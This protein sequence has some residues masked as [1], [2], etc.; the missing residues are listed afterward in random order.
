MRE[1]RIV[2]NDTIEREEMSNLIDK[3]ITARDVKESSKTTY[4]K[5]LKQFMTWIAGMRT[6][7][8]TRETILHYKSHIEEKGLTALTLSNYIGA[9]R[10][11]FEWLEEENIYPNVAKGIKGAKKP[12]G[13]RKDTFTIEQVKALFSSA[14]RNTL[15]GKRD[16]AILNLLVRTGLRTIEVA[17]ANFDDIRQEAGESILWVKDKGS[18]SKDDFVLLMSET[19]GAIMEYLNARGKIKEKAPLFASLSNRNNGGRLTTKSVSRVVKEHLRE[20]GI[21]SGR[22]TAHSLRHTFATLALRG[23]AHIVQVKEAMGHRSIDT[24]MIY[25]HLLDR[26]KNGAERYINI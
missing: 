19:M 3:F 16:Y 15:K 17:G 11:F 22:L 5:C 14:D 25:A 7:N 24:T 1:Q 10:Q 23:G 8:P 21:V 20:V 12:R 4:R 26:I 13:F 6:V 18:D 2:G 9:V